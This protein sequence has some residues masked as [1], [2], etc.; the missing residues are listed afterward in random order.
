[1]PVVKHEIKEPSKKAQQ[2]KNSKLKSDTIL[3]VRHGGNPLSIDNGNFYRSGQD[4]LYKAI[5][6]IPICKKCIREIF[7]KYYYDNNSDYLKAIYLMCRKLDIIYETNS[8]EGAFKKCKGNIE[9][10][11]G[12]YIGIVG[13]GLREG[14]HNLNFDASEYVED[15]QT[16]IDI[17]VNQIR[18]EYKFTEDDLRNMEDVAK[19]LG[20]DPFKSSGYSEYDLGQLYSE[21]VTY[22]EDDDLATDA[23]KLNIVLQIINGNHQIRQMDLYLSLL[24][25]GLG[26]FENNAS[27]ISTLYVNREKLIKM[28]NAT[29]RENTWLTLD[30]SGKNKLGGLLKKYRNYGYDEIQPNYFDMATCESVKKVIDLSHQS[31]MDTLNF[32]DDEAKDIL[33]MQRNLIAEKDG[34]IAKIHEEKKKLAIELVELKKKLS[35]N[36]NE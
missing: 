22:L 20:Y 8:A 14:K 13:S 24:N 12:S 7:M 18:N 25:S 32:G 9:S 36:K 3:C 30:T 33:L 35:Y 21:L 4:S 17:K 2:R 16:S 27:K 19:K 28:N 11:F 6:Y 10:V 31:I 23:Y 15:N 1:M 5:G 26:D 34:E 29:K